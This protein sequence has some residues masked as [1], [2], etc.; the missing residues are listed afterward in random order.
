MLERDARSK[1]VMIFSGKFGFLVEF[2]TRCY[3]GPKIFLANSIPDVAHEL[4]PLRSGDEAYQ[5]KLY[6]S[7]AHMIVLLFILE[8]CCSRIPNILK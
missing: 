5:I 4:V 2:A 8:P 6:L 1:S 7:L 3:C